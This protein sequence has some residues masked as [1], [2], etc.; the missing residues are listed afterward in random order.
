ML[1]KFAFWSTLSE[2]VR[3]FVQS[4]IYCLWTV[5]GERVPRPFGTALHGTKP[6]DLLQFDYIELAPSSEGDK[7]VLML[8]DDHSVYKWFYAFVDT[9]S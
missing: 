8:L 7:Y 4:C 1:N 3:S 2:D 9:A 5:G 6:N